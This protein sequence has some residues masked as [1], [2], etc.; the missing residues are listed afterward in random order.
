M[1][2]LKH[3]F[4]IFLFVSLYHDVLIRSVVVFI[5]LLFNTQSNEMGI[6]SFLCIIFVAHLFHVSASFI[7]FHNIFL[8]ISFL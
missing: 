2:V 8:Q 1:N 6:S 4:I 5:V 3:K 7:I